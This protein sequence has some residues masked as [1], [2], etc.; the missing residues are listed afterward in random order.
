MWGRTTPGLR[1]NGH[2][3]AGERRWFKR[4]KLNTAILKTAFLISARDW[5]RR[6]TAP[7]PVHLSFRRSSRGSS[8]GVRPN[9]ASMPFQPPFPRPFSA[10]TIRAHAPAGS[11]VYGLSNGKHWIYIGE[12][13]DILK[14]LL[15]HLSDSGNEIGRMLPTGFCCEMSDPAVRSIRQERLVTEYGPVCNHPLALGVNA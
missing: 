11:G 8:T 3:R 10:R 14:A 15:G 2:C 4:T 7:A 12:T 9:Q 6:F 1:S 13:D 5:N